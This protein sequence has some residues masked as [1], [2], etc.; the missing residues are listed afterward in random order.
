MQNRRAHVLM[1]WKNVAFKKRKQ[2]LLQKRDK[3]RALVK[4]VRKLRVPQNGK[5]FLIT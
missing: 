5:N 2:N 4:A 1:L 3:C